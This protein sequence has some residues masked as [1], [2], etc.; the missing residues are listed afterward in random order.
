MKLI[1]GGSAARGGSHLNGAMP[2]LS[3]APLSPADR[4]ECYRNLTW[5]ISDRVTSTVVH[6]HLVPL[7]VPDHSHTV[8]VRAVVAGQDQ[9]LVRSAG[10]QGEQRS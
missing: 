1:L 7:E 5:W 4:R 3:R 10:D 6:R 8:S 9:K 2:G